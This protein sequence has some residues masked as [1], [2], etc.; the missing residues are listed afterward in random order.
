L[1]LARG[2]VAVRRRGENFIRSHGYNLM[3]IDRGAYLLFC[4][5]TLG[6]G[7]EQGWARAAFDCGVTGVSQR[8]CLTSCP[9][10]M[11]GG[12]HRIGPGAVV[13]TGG[14]YLGYFNG[15]RGLFHSCLLTAFNCYTIVD[16]LGRG[17][18]DE[19]SSTESKTG[20]PNTVSGFEARQTGIS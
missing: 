13:G 15:G 8:P 10:S 2:L 11:G 20:V 19:V 17:G 18:R 9:A 3:D 4:Y 12:R 14:P 1:G 7:G 5:K 16:S 6:A